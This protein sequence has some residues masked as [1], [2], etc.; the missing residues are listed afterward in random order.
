MELP[1]SCYEMSDTP[2][3]DFSTDAMPDTSTFDAEVAFALVEW[4][5]CALREDDPKELYDVAIT[6]REV[7]ESTP[8]LDWQRSLTSHKDLHLRKDRLCNIVPIIFLQKNF[9]IL[10]GRICGKSSFLVTKA[11][12]S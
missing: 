12:L 6:F 11:Q 1:G 5:C 8:Y 3:K 10:L 7:C 2:C 9:T 4:Y